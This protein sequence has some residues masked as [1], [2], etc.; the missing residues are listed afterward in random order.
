M[1]FI[2]APIL[3]IF[4][5]TGFPEIREALVDHEVTSSIAMTLGLS[6][7]A[8]FFFAILS[9]PLSWVFSRRHFRGKQFL[10]GI[11]NIPI[12]IPH[13][14][15]G[16]ALLSVL[17]PQTLSGTFASGLDI[18]GTRT[19]I[20]L[21]MAF[22][23]IPFLINASIDGF[24]TVPE[25]LEKAALNLGASPARV[26]FTISLPLAWRQILTGAIMMFG[27]GMSEFGAVIIIAYHPMSVPVLIYERFTSFGLAYARP[28]AVVFITISLLIFIMLRFIPNH[29]TKRR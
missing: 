10:R 23:S 15:A 17:S 19:G 16:I 2:I 13:T 27:R 24:S 22:V 28:V 3:G 11:V 18:M 7:M 29:E 12:I 4:L 26:F 21:G 1:L 25:R 20:A 9:V 6:F 14:A 8:T 5:K